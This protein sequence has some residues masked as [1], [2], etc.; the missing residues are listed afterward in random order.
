MVTVSSARDPLWWG[1]H[2]PDRRSMNAALCCRHPCPAAPVLGLQTKIILNPLWLE[3]NLH[4]CAVLVS[5]VTRPIV[6]WKM[7]CLL[8]SS[9]TENVFMI[10]TSCSRGRLEVD[11]PTWRLTTG[12]FSVHAD[13]N[14]SIP[15]VVRLS[16][17][18]YKI[19]VLS[20]VCESTSPC[21]A[22][23]GSTFAVLLSAVWKV[24][25]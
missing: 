25:E 1:H 17:E 23:V 12:F 10:L 19:I 7:Q 20:I 24:K 18:C 21:L 22:V 14:M 2:Y 16:L 15:I 4:V 6:G 11:S 9:C 3:D 5:C 8:F 13:Q